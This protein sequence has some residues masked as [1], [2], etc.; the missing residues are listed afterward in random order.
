MEAGPTYETNHWM[1]FAYPD[2][3]LAMPPHLVS[4]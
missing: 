1:E 4:I 3:A 2:P